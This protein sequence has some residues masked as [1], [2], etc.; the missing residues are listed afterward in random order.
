MAPCSP[1]SI[2]V[3]TPPPLRRPQA[4]P[5]GDEECDGFGHLAAR[6]EVDALVEAVDVLR[7]RAIDQRRHLGVEAE[8]AGIGRAGQRPLRQVLAEH[9][10]VAWRRAASASVPASWMIAFGLETVPDDLRRAVGEEGSSRAASGEQVSTSPRA[11]ARSWSGK[12]A[13]AHVEG[14]PGRARWRPSRRPRSCRR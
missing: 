1:G 11:V 10:L 8:E 6:L 13:G 14:A 7:D 9:R 5:V 2:E 4:A 3:V 12:T